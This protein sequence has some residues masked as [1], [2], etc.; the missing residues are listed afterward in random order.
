[1][2]RG[3][4]GYGTKSGDGECTGDREGFHPGWV[5]TSRVRRTHPSVAAL[6]GLL[7]VWGW[8]ARTK[9]KALEDMRHA[10]VAE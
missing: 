4:G 2:R 9:G 6:G 7:F 10:T 3:D 5:P 8:V 1:M